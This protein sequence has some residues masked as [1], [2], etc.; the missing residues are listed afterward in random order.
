MFLVWWFGYVWPQCIDLCECYAC[1]SWL[2]TFLL[3]QHSFKFNHAIMLT[4]TQMLT[5]VSL[6]AILIV[7][8]HFSEK[9]SSDWI[10]YLEMICM[11]MNFAALPRFGIIEREITFSLILIKYECN[12]MSHNFFFLHIWLYHFSA[13][14]S[15]G[16]RVIAKNLMR[17]FRLCLAST[18]STSSLRCTPL[19]VR[20]KHWTRSLTRMSSLQ[21]VDI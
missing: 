9:K 7:A 20:Q 3:V 11:N 19:S 12:G 17:T 5:F 18:P 1:V 4:A 8:F 21:I 16:Y 13:V 6:L 10:K 14:A 2:H 15:F